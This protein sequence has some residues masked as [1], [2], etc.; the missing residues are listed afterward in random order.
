MLCS[1][2]TEVMNVS[3]NVAAVSHQFL[4]ASIDGPWPEELSVCG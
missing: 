4:G 1:Q 2:F 3:I